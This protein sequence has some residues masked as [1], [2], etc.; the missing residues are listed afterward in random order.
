M[1]AWSPEFIAYACPFIACT[2]IAPALDNV[3]AACGSNV[4][5]HNIHLDLLKLV[6]K[7]IGTFW[8]I[9]TAA[10]SKWFL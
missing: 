9:G 5:K 6:L 10:L 4:D 3:R 7:R 8:D 1:Q 2:I